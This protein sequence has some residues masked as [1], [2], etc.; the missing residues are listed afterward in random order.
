MAVEETAS[1]LKYIQSFNANMLKIW[2]ER[3]A[4][5]GV[6]RSG[7]LYN[8]IVGIKLA[9]NQDA[10][11]VEFEWGFLEYGKFQDSGTGREVAIGN[12]GDIGR[13]KVRQRRPWLSKSLYSSTMNLKE[14]MADSLGREAMQVISNAF[15]DSISG[16]LGL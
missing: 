3:I 6:I 14:F 8:S 5:L 1:R 2:Q 4:L 12:P 7:A 10:S 16:V 13:P 15:R 9:A 11:D